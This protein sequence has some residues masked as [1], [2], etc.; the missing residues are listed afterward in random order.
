MFEIFAICSHARVTC[1]HLC[2]VVFIIYTIFSQIS[3]VCPRDYPQNIVIRVI[4]YN[5]KILEDVTRNFSISESAIISLEDL[6]TL[7]SNERYNSE[8]FF[9][10]PSK[11]F[12]ITGAVNFSEH[13]H[14]KF[15]H[16]F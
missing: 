13:T 3:G 2:T 11:D 4:R 12:N 9:Q 15:T 5:D 10:N 8:I 16:L 6:L 7:N 1:V 14:V